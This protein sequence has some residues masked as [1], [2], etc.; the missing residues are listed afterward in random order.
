M[1]H[2]LGRESRR[3]LDELGVVRIVAGEGQG[4]EGDLLFADRVI[5][6]ELGQACRR[7]LRPGAGRRV[8]QRKL[9]ED[10]I[11]ADRTDGTDRATL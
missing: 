10:F 8:K 2:L 9:G 3:A 1:L 4:I 5:G 11:E 7:E 6:Q